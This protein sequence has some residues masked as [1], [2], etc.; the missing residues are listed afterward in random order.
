M[1]LTRLIQM[2]ICLCLLFAVFACS[3]S[4][5]NELF[6]LN[7]D[8]TTEQDFT[9]AVFTIGSLWANEVWY[10]E[11][12]ITYATDLQRD[13]IDS[14]KDKFGC[15]YKYV[16]MQDT[17]AET[18]YLVAAGLPTTDLFDG[19]VCN[20]G[21]AFYKANLLVPPKNV[22]TIDSTDE[23]KWGTFAFRSC[24]IFD[25]VCYGFFT[26]Q[27]QNVMPKFSGIM[28]FNAFLIK[29][30]GLADPYE[31]QEKGLWNWENYEELLTSAQKS[32]QI[33]NFVP[34]T[35]FEQNLNHVPK[36]FIFSNGAEFVVKNGDKL[37]FGFNSP[38]AADALAYVAELYD[39]QLYQTKGGYPAFTDGKA[40]FVTAE[41][42]F[43]TQT[44][45]PI[46]A[47]NSME[48][49][50]FISFPYGPHGDPSTVSAYSHNGGRLNYFLAYGPNDYNDTGTVVD[51]VYSYLDGE[52]SGWDQWCRHSI[53]QYEQ[54]YENIM[55]MVYGMKY[56]YSTQ[57]TDSYSDVTSALLNAVMGKKTP[58]EALSGVTERV[59]EDIKKNLSWFFDPNKVY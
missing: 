15:E 55:R 12:G 47:P 46:Y 32:I 40:V 38:L 10:T 13:R 44:N 48:D 33:E 6:D 21:Y 11:P 53:F 17:T 26:W 22:E 52:D 24:G 41:S 23:E 56:D 36:G 2:L 5:S 54:G 43:A 58:S 19:H 37:E 1:K 34:Y 7:Y 45:S 25:D 9:G 50:G 28:M 57:L 14:V 49:W 4:D 27:W 29:Q 31:L 42:D 35:V 39:K 20:T 18:F 3:S 59:N 16:V 51:Y 30:Y 8:E